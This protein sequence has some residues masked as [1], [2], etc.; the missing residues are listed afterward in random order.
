M[1]HFLE[2]PWSNG[3][4]SKSAAHLSAAEK[5]LSRH[6]K[7]VNS[8]FKNLKKLSPPPPFM[9]ELRNFVKLRD[10]RLH[11]VGLHMYLNR[12]RICRLFP[13]NTGDQQEKM[14]EYQEHESLPRLFE[15]H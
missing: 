12:A 3:T 10:Q 1:R 14:S 2:A 4:Q 5:M 7:I 8:C 11:H 6:E 13:P 15:I 9:S